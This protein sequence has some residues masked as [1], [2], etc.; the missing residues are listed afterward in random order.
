MRKFLALLL[1]LP[2]FLATTSSARAQMMGSQNPS[3]DQTTIQQ[4]QAEE[5]EGK[6]LLDQLKNKTTTCQKV[7]N[8]NFEKIGEYFMGR[9]IGDTSRHIQMNNM[10]K[11]MMGKNGEEQMHITWGK[12]QSGCENTTGN[13]YQGGG[14]SMMGYGMMGGMYGFGLLGFI[15]WIL[16]IIALV[17]L[18][19]LLWKQIQKK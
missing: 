17:L 13:S 10:M 3:I 2:I 6:K 11:S 14:N 8:D 9:A 4:Q 15:T 19:V 1:F 16:I 5:Q 12:Q 18:I 7:T